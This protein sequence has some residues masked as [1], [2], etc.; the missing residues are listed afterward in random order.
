MARSYSANDT[1]R[2]SR[3]NHGPQTNQNACGD[4]GRPVKGTGTL[5]KNCREEFT[6]IIGGVK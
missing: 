3:M 5:C 2:D 6:D 4:C 1:V